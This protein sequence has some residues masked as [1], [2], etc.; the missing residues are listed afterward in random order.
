MRREDTK[1]E[2]SFRAEVRAW[3]EANAPRREAHGEARAL[4][5]S[6]EAEARAWEAMKVWQRRKFEGGWA[7]ITWP[8]EYGGRGGTRIEQMIYSEEESAFDVPRGFISASLGMI[9]PALM[10]YGTETQ[11]AY[12]PAML[13]GDEVWCQLFS[14]PEAG[15]DLAAVRTRG[16]V[17][18]DELVIDGQKVWTTS[19]QFADKGF[20]VLRT[21]PDVPKHDGISF[22]LI[23][24]KQPGVEVRPLVTM[25]GD[26][27]FNEVFLSGVR[28]PLD[29]VVNGLNRGWPVT[30]FVLMNEGAFIG[31]TAH[32]ATNTRRLI[33]W[34]R[35]TGRLDEPVARERLGEAHVR[36][37]VLGQLQDRLKAALLDGRAPDVDASVL[38]ILAA[39]WGHE[40]AV[41]ATA[42]QGAAGL[43]AGADAPVA[44]LWQDQILSRGSTAVGGGTLEVHRNGLGE[45]ALRL[46]KEP[47]F[48]REMA[49]KDLK[50]S[51]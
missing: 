35:D 41:T 6:P 19:A 22:A 51:G 47:R 20:I 36:E 15:S 33:E 18:G 30:T 40:R 43:L 37:R 42:L 1:E 24:M 5:H 45:R 34:A 14:E 12:L 29:H 3:L 26:R 50:T 9:G 31:T 23:D 7:A 49:F 46:P 11:K 44:G 28:T 27:H 2:A 38:K 17:D 48:D 32:N 8:E 39:E 25:R 21:D 16:R 13:R 4:D 10:R